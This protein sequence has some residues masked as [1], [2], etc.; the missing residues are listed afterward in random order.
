M[1]TKRSFDGRGIELTESSQ[2]QLD[3]RKALQ[4]LVFY[5][6]AADEESRFVGVS[7]VV[8]RTFPFHELKEDRVET[9]RQ[10]KFRP[11]TDTELATAW[12][13]PHWAC[14]FPPIL[15]VNQAA[16]L[17]QIPKA[18]VYDWSARKLLTDCSR[19]CGKHLR[20]FRDRLIRFY[21]ERGIASK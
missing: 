7:G 9:S 1:D 14:K 13:D 12:S 19:R 4:S 21:F 2:R 18:T 10:Q 16:E 15:T 3:C 5:R 20:F 17:L 8:R 6:A 11:I